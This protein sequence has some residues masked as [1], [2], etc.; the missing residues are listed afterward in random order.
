MKCNVYEVSCNQNHISYNLDLI[1]NICF[2]LN[3]L[4]YIQIDP[5]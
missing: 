5:V 3:T 1:L 2:I 4:E